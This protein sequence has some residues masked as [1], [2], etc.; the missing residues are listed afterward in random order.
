M[1]G[2]AGVLLTD[3]RRERRRPCRPDRVRTR[4]SRRVT[5]PGRGGPSPRS[6]DPDRRAPWHTFGANGRIGDRRDA[7]PTA[8]RSTRRSW[9]RR[10]TRRRRCSTCS[11]RKRSGPRLSW[12]AANI[13]QRGADGQGQLR[14]AR[15]AAVSGRR[16]TTQRLLRG[17]IV[18]APS[19]SRTRRGHSR[20]AKYG[21]LADEPLIEATIPTLTDRASS[22]MSAQATCDT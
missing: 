7:R 1:P 14:A 17:R 10:S 11:S 19:M 15:A 3:S 20:P 16:P 2:T 12:R 4:R 18:F 22:T 21:E 9:S 5:T 8:T 6:R 13:R